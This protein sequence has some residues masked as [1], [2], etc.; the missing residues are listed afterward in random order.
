M[1]T[2]I[3]AKT[4]DVR[5]FAAIVAMGIPWKEETCSI[6]GGERAWL[7]GD[8]SDCGKWK[9]KDLLSWWRDRNFHLSNPTHPFNVVKCVMA[10]DKGI[11]TALT[12]NKGISQ[13]IL[14]NSRVIDP[15]D[16]PTANIATHRAS[17]DA[18]LVSSLSGY[19]FEIKESKQIGQT[20]FFAASEFT[21]FDGTPYDS[22]ITWWR[23]ASFERNNPQHPF[24]YAKSASITY[25]AAVEAIRAE[26]PL[27]RWKPSGSVGFAYIHPDCSSET[28]KKVGNWLNNK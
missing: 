21:S 11:K 27:I 25:S 10:S 14:G 24:A 17:N 16:E 20:R 26:R 6:A 18:S 1:A 12:T 19:G 22:V 8:V 28:E 23:D 3:Q 4:K 5:L 7:F 15:I 2:M 9:I 13:R